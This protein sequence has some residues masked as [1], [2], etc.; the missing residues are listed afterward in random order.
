MMRKTGARGLRAIMEMILLD[1]MYEIPS[2]KNIEKVLINKSVIQKKSVPVLIYKNHQ[3]I[4]TC[5]KISKK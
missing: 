2:I 3:S 1:I 5:N 4:E